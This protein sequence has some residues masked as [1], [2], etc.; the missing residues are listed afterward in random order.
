[1]ALLMT[2]LITWINTGFD[3]GFWGRWFTA[4]YIAWPIAGMLVF[5]G[6]QRIR[7]LSEKIAA[8]I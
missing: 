4:F 3:A 8:K 5:V 6:G 1:M 7:A 2:C